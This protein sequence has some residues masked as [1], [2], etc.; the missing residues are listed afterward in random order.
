M[1]N[2][3][4]YPSMHTLQLGEPDVSGDFIA[5]LS[6]DA[7]LGIKRRLIRRKVFKMKFSVALHK[8]FNIFSSMPC[9]SI[10]VEPNMVIPQ[11]P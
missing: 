5:G 8:E 9:G 2:S 11:L 6:P 10:H 1:M 3:L 7:F 4:G